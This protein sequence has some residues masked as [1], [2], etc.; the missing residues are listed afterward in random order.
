MFY[1]VWIQPTDGPLTVLERGPKGELGWVDD[2][3]A[4]VTWAKSRRRRYRNMD[5]LVRAVPDDHPV[6]QGS[7]EI[8]YRTLDDAELQE[9]TRA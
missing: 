9:E 3:E 1:E 5:F 8:V 4:A 2:Q 6:P 7:P